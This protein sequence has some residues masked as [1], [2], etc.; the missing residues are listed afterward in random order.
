MHVGI[1]TGFANYAKVEDARFLQEELKQLVLVDE[2]GFDSVWMTEHH[3]DDYSISPAPLMT[4][5]W[6]AARTKRVRLGTAVIVAPWHDP[7]RLAEQISWLDHLSGGRA[8]IGFGRGLARLEFEGLRIDQSKARELFDEVVEM[9]M[10]A[11]ETGFIE[12]GKLFNQPRREIRP[13]PLRSLKGR[14]FVARRHAGLAPIDRQIGS[15]AAVSQSA[16][17]DVDTAPAFRRQPDHR[18]TCSDHSRVPRRSVAQGVDGIPAARAAARTLRLEPRLHG[19]QP[20]SRL[21]D[22]AALC[23]KHLP[24][25]D[26]AL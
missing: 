8:V 26:Q 18:G 22:G 11:M 3:F 21:R 13:R 20:R 1:C 7:V 17:D 16:D 15:A 6:L 2:L 24:L 25:R 9:V 4:L 14:A 5:A 23:G 12:G 10:N 19:R